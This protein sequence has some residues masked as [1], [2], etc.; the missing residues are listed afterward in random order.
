MRLDLLVSTIHIVLP[1]KI[2]S[3]APGHKENSEQFT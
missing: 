3:K 1:Q 2:K